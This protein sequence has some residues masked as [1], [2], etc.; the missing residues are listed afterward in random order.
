ML[1][2]GYLGLGANCPHP[3]PTAVRGSVKTCASS[4]P[5]AVRRAGVL[6]GRRRV[7]DLATTLLESGVNTPGSM[8][9]AWLPRSPAYRDR[10]CLRHGA[11]PWLRQT[12][13][14]THAFDDAAAYRRRRRAMQGVRPA[15]SVLSPRSLR[16]TG[17]LAVECKQSSSPDV[18]L[19]P[20]SPSRCC[21]KVL[22][23]S[24]AAVARGPPSEQSA[25][26]AASACCATLEAAL[27]DKRNRRIFVERSN[28]RQ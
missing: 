4:R 22:R 11:L 21:A 18:L 12:H 16:V 19:L 23:P 17:A 2:T 6:T 10:R 28:Q 13:R 26:E 20:D 8:R 7:V 1:M 25:E 9:R 3:R 27:P 14:A 24:E 15:P 5:R